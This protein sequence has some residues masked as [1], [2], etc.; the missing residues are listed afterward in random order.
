M[1]GPGRT[2]LPGAPSISR[3]GLK[4][5]ATPRGCRASP[6]TGC[7]RTTTSTATAWSVPD[8]AWRQ[9][10]APMRASRITTATTFITSRRTASE[11]RWTRTSATPSAVLTWQARGGVSV[12]GGIEYEDQRQRGTSEFSASFGTFPDSIRAHR[13]NAGY[14]TQAIIPMGRAAVTLGSRLDDN[15]QFGTHATYRAGAVYRLDQARLRASVGTG[16]KEP[17]F[18]ENFARGIATGNPHLKPERSLSW[19]VGVERGAVAVTYFNQR[20]RDLIEYSSTPVG[21][22]SVNYFNVGAAIA[23]GVEL[24]LDQSVTTRVALSVKY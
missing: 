4:G 3:V 2:A 22:D 24:S 9:T 18:F 11:R 7:I 20:F 1:W 23:D 17:T 16:Y 19:E 14:F 6:P 15:S 12:I 13:N 8:C 10:R 5:S 21:P